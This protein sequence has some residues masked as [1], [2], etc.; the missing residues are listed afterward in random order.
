MTTSFN[1]SVVVVTFQHDSIS[2]AKRTS[3]T[4][5]SKLKEGNIKHFLANITKIV[6][7]RNQRFFLLF[8]HSDDLLPQEAEQGAVQ[9]PG[10]PV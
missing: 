2:Y 9:E 1:K 5:D 3:S 10:D 4:F 7:F 8:S 6:L